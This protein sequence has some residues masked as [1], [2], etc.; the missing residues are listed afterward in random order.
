MNKKKLIVVLLIAGVGIVAIGIILFLIFGK[1]SERLGNGQDVPTLTVTPTIEATSPSTTPS[2]SDTPTTSTTV[3]VT[4]TLVVT[5]S[6][7]TTIAPKQYEGFTGSLWFAPPMTTPSTKRFNITVP[8]GEYAYEGHVD[9]MANGCGWSRITDDNIA[10]NEK[11]TFSL[12]FDQDCDYNGK[13][14]LG[15]SFVVVRT[16]SQA[17][18]DGSDLHWVRIKQNTTTYLYVQVLT[19]QGGKV[20]AGDSFSYALTIHG[21]VRGDSN[22][23]A[24]SKLILSVYNTTEDKAKIADDMVKSF[25]MIE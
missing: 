19:E 20:K 25:K 18:D 5:T 12:K 1:P 14:K 15:Q 9:S 22:S 23:A 11:G 8:K 6:V 7:P 2:I 4:P 3:T 17:A 24:K 13:G 10:S 16:Y 21:K